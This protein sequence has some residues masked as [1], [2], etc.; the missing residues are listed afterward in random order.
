M[1]SIDPSGSASDEVPNSDSN[2]NS[3]PDLHG[4][5][6]ASRSEEK[7][8]STAPEDGELPELDHSVHLVARFQKG[9]EEALADLWARYEE[10]LRRIVRVELRAQLRPKLDPEDVL[11][12]AYLQARKNMTSFELRSHGAILGWL[13]TI[14]RNRLRDDWKR[15]TAERRDVGR[16]SPLH[17]MVDTDRSEEFIELTETDN[18]PSK[19]A[20]ANEIQTLVDAAVA[21]LQPEDQRRAVV[22]RDYYDL[23]W[24]EIAEELGKPTPEAARELH[25][26]GRLKL[27]ERVRDRLES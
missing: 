19:Y 8:D 15:F 4:A 6:R 16:E 12:D 25:S 26:R 1:Q 24:A 10:R 5:S 21:S 2:G 18:T 14:V 11:Q 22:L 3:D 7:S 23:S 13:A 17:R 27:L 9:D 20:S